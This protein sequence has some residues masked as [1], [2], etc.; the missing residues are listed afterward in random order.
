[1]D[2]G[3]E[4]HI[5]LSSNVADVLSQISRWRNFVHDLGEAEVKHGV[6]IHLFNLYSDEVGNPARPR[7]LA[8]SSEPAPPVSKTRKVSLAKPSTNDSQ[9]MA[10][11]AGA[12]LGPYEIV[13]FV[14]AGGMGEV[15]RA[16]DTRL[17]RSVAIKILPASFA[18]DPDR[19]R[20]FEQE[21]RAVAALNHPNILAIHDIGTQD[22]TSYLVSEFLE[23]NTLREQLANEALPARK[24]IEYAL[25]IAQGLGAAHDKGIVHRDLKPE[26]IFITE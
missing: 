7:K 19:L 18:S 4:G 10:V 11:S 24:A 2:C 20:R 22:G 21:A 26:N 16:R 25:Q 13:S 5:L 3:D 15:Y 9:P 17:E 6:R 1:M 14:A 12:R 23:G 8:T